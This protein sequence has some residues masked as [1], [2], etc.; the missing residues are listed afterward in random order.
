[1]DGE[2][3]ICGR[4]AS[5]EALLGCYMCVWGWMFVC[6]CWGVWSGLAA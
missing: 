6:G 4:E 2:P 3:Q 5:K 1:M